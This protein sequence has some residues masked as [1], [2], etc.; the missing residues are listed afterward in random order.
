MGMGEAGLDQQP[1]VC[2]TSTL[3]CGELVSPPKL[4]ATEVTCPNCGTLLK[5]DSSGTLVIVENA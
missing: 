5:L 2:E 4:P 3:R 1:L